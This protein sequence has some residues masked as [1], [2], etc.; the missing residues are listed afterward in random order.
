MACLLV[1]HPHPPSLPVSPAAGLQSE[2]VPGRR[3]RER[4]RRQ[5]ALGSS[6]IMAQRER[7][8]IKLRLN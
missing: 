7:F 8:S 4:D 1:A 5:R 3:E 6:G 2:A